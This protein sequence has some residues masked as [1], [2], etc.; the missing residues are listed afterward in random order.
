VAVSA[1]VLGLAANT[2][3]HFRISAANPEG[4]SYGNDETFHTPPNP[5]TVVSGAASALS[6]SYATLNAMVNP[7]GG[8]VAACLFEY[9]TSASYGSTAP[10]SS[11]GQTGGSP[12][13]VS[14]A[15]PVGA[16][17]TYH[18]RIVATNAGGTSYGADETF[19]TP[20]TPPPRL[21]VSMTW[22]WSDRDTVIRSLTVHRVP[23]GAS[24]EVACAGHGCPFNNRRA[25][26]IVSHT[27]CRA[28]RCAKRH[29]ALGP[30]VSL[31]GLFHSRRLDSGARISVSIVKAGW[32]GKS[33]VFIVRPGHEPVPDI[34]CLAPGSSQPGRGC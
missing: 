19:T 25:V 2:T 17:T 12:A 20:A 26:T 11:T 6:S 30:T 21:E 13:A 34:A 15:V 9:G 10:C 22:R 24:V 3:Y 29:M 27:S 1:S 33:Y 5:P 14:A 32:I 23:K 8:Q 7:N 4:S 18:F 31:A 16:A 28:R